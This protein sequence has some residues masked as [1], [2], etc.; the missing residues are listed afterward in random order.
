VQC[1]MYRQNGGN[2]DTSARGENARAVQVQSLKMIGYPRWE[3]VTGGCGHGQWP[4][5]A[6]QYYIDADRYLHEIRY[7]RSA[8]NW[9]LNGERRFPT[10]QEAQIFAEQLT[11]S[12]V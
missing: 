1:I 5:K 8:R 4:D 7:D 12:K 3:F 11:A 6:C 2:A 10:L 9:L